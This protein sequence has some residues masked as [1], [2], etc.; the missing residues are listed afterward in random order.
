MPIF[1]P[2]TASG[3][4]VRIDV[5][6]RRRGAQVANSAA[7]VDDLGGPAVGRCEPVVDRRDGKAGSEGAA[8][9]GLG[10]L[11]LLRHGGVPNRPIAAVDDE[12]QR[13]NSRAPEWLVHVERL[14]LAAISAVGHRGRGA[15]SLV[16][17][18]R[19]G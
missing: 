4:L 15:R 12:E 18:R 11:T 9:R 10:E 16:H 1:V 3:E 14:R 17:A 8:H 13:V 19:D 6:P 7:G 5:P 2:H